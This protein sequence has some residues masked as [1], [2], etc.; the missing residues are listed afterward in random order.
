MIKL[1]F[2]AAALLAS[3]AV[4]ASATPADEIFNAAVF[5]INESVAKLVA[6]QARRSQAPKADPKVVTCTPA[7][8]DTAYVELRRCEAS[9]KAA[10]GQDV[11]DFKGS[12]ITGFNYRS[13]PSLVLLTTTDAFFY[14]EDCDICAAVERCSLKDGSIKTFKAAHSVDCGD[15]SAFLKKDVAF[16]SCPLP[17]P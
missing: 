1:P 10:Y 7:Q 3:L 4:T 2:A 5:N 11:R 16:S 13:G 17:K 12:L 6:A 9:M 8:I 14:H 15:L